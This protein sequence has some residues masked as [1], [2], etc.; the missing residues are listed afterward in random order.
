MGIANESVK[1]ILLV[2]T[3]RIGDVVLSLPMLP[4]IKK[5]FPNASVT[6]MV[7]PYTKELV[8]RHSCVDEII[9]WDESLGISHYVPLLR[10]KGFDVAIL[11]YPR[12]NLSLI[13]FLARIPLRAGTGF[14]WYSFLFTKRI[15]EHRKDAKRHEV[16]YNVNLLST[17]GIAPNGEPVFEFSIPVETE[18]A[19]HEKLSADGV[20]R[21]AVLHAGSG[22]SARDWSIENFARLGD[23]LQSQ[24]QLQVVLTGGSN[25]RHLTDSLAAKM[26]N[27]PYNYTSEFSLQE[28]G[29]LFRHASVFVSNSTGPLHIAAMVGT[30]VVAFYPPILQCSPA[31]WGPYTKKKKVFAADNNACALCQGTPCRSNVCMEQITVEHVVAAIRGLLNEKN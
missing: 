6:M 25:E 27:P 28:L 4:L 19:V 18:K 5:Q 24:L 13:A 20:R 11:P 9:L 14:R 21:F 16:E 29:A 3:D 30:P 22:G 8:E 23:E 1:K 15:Y 7:R 17:L 12:F 10:S 2:R 26:K 31:R